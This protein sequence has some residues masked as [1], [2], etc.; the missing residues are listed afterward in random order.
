MAENCKLAIW[1]ISQSFNDSVL[2]SLQPKFGGKIID[3]VSSD[4]QTPEQQSIAWNEVKNTIFD[5]FLVVI[6]GYDYHLVIFFG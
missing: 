3:I 4:I 2:F 6:V 5:I 1:S